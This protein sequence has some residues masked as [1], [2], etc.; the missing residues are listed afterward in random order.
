MLEVRKYS[1]MLGK[2]LKNQE[3]VSIQDIFVRSEK[4]IMGHIF[5]IRRVLW[6]PNNQFY[7]REL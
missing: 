6:I 3:N 7:K 2:V 4:H 5:F 1:D